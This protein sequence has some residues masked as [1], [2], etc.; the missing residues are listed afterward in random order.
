MKFNVY[1]MTTRQTNQPDPEL[2]RTR[3]GLGE[4]LSLRLT[5]GFSLIELLVVVAI[6]GIIF[7]IAVPH[8][9]ST[10]SAAQA[11]GARGD[12]KTLHSAQVG[13]FSGAG[14]GKYGT[15]SALEAQKLLSAGFS[16]SNVT[17]HKS[18]Y[19]GTL[20]L[21]DSDTT[22][23]IVSVPPAI[24]ATTPSFYLDESGALRIDSE[25]TATASSTLAGQ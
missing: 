13:Y 21:A 22:F 3:R 15:L 20:T 11:A 25:S 7:S 18:N 1:A 14:G 23:S 6:L 5:R 4:I 2:G 8:Y 9:L 24:S 17:Y 10:R 19:S 16:S 12:L